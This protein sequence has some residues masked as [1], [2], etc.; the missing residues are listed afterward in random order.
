M[1][2]GQTGRGFQ[3]VEFTDRGGEVCSIQESSA[4][5][6]EGLIWLGC[7]DLNVK[8]MKEGMMGWH[9]LDIKNMDGVKEFVANNRMHLSQS[10]VKDL[11]PL[12]TY[13]A[14]HGILPS[15]ED[16]KLEEKQ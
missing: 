5:D 16:S 8:V 13:F 10:M 12:L 15:Q 1:K 9:D 2:F 11:L 6:E 3:L 4:M 7:K 14:E